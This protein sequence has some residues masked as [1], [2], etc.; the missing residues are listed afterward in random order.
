MLLMLK[1][2]FRMLNNRG[3]SLILFVIVLPVLL[4]ILVLVIDIG[5]VISLKQELNNISEIVLDYGIDYLNND[6]D[7]NIDSISSIENKLIEIIELNKDDIDE[8]DVRIDNNKINILLSDSVD[9]IFSSILDIDM[10]DI[11][12]SY[13]GYMDN[14]KK[15]IERVNG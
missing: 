2:L 11:K 3:Q 4:L 13:V 1:G 9:G 15:R 14:N 7:D 10:F 8:I 12:S 5:K 6:M